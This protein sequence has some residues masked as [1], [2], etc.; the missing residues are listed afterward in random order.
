[1][2]YSNITG[3]AI[4]YDSHLSW[5][6]PAAAKQGALSGIYF[7]FCPLEYF[8]P[9]LG[10]YIRKKDIFILIDCF[11]N[12]CE[13]KVPHRLPALCGT[14]QAAGENTRKSGD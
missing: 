7:Y 10:K 12:L 13:N 3:G 11:I 2:I 6:S 4:Y 8:L 9:E 14:P 1:M 5:R